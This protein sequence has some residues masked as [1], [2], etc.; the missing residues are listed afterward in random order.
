MDVSS[1][2]LISAALTSWRKLGE[3]VG[4]KANLDAVGKRQTSTALQ[5]GPWLE[6]LFIFAYKDVLLHTITASKC[7]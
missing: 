5:F 6:R 1:Q 3:W 4:A 7:Y 2:L